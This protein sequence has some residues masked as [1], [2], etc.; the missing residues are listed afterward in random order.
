VTEPHHPLPAGAARPA[1][2]AIE[3]LLVIH[4]MKTAGTSLRWMLDEEL[5]PGGVYPN[6][7]DLDR[8]RKRWYPK[9]REIIDGFDDLPP[10]R[11]LI[12]HFPASIRDALPV[13]YQTATFLRDPIQ[14][15]ASM[16]T[17]RRRMSGL[18]PV[19]FEQLLDDRRLVEDQV[20]DYQTK[21]L[22]MGLRHVNRPWPTDDET[23][24]TA[25][26]RLAEMEFVGLTERFA[27]SCEIF[28]RRFATRISSRMRRDNAYRSTSDLPDHLVQR[29][30]PLVERDLELHR[31]ALDR[32]ERS[33]RHRR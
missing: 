22:G 5:G 9:V 10:H 7:A 4:I 15:T 3:R 27:E 16:L 31:I 30:T 11:V 17:H 2:P 28:D 8:R 24:N 18:G 21:V 33:L 29:I 1:G 12:G 13:A 6:D 26:D 20:A 25:L 32:F 14:R 23:L 19:P